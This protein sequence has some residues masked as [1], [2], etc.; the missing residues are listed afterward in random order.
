MRALR[1][2]AVVAAALGA[3]TGTAAAAEVKADLVLDCGGDIACEKYNGGVPKWVFSFTAAPGE[4]ND[5]TVR[6]Q[7]DTLTVRDSGAPLTTGNRCARVSDN[8]ASAT[9]RSSRGRRSR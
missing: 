6:L 7:G 9:C 2:L 8:E 5:A 3:T 1:I 4:A